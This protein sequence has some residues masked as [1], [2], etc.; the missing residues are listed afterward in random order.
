MEYSGI[1][2]PAV[3][4]VGL[5][6]VAVRLRP[7]GGKAGILAREL[8]EL[9]ARWLVLAFLGGGWSRTPESVRWWPL[10]PFTLSAV[11][12]SLLAFFF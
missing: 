9:D 3:D 5:M 1:D 8:I 10:P 2:G 12:G 11:V 6:E 7:S 4:L